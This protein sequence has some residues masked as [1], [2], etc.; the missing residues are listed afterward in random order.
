[1]P[2]KIATLTPAQTARMPE[3]V[4]KWLAIGLSTEPGDMDAAEE[5]VRN[6]YASIKAPAPKVVLRMASP[7]GAIVGGLMAEALLQGSASAVRSQVESQV[8]DQVYSQVE[9]QVWNQVRRQVWNQVRNQVW[10]QVRSQVWS[11][12]E[13]QVESQVESQVWSQVRS[14]VGSQ[15]W[16]QVRRQVESRVGNQV[17]SRWSDS[18][19]QNLNAGWHA[20]VTFFRDV[21]GWENET[22]AAYANDEILSQH[23]SWTWWAPEVAAIVDKPDLLSR[24]AEGRLHSVTG[25]A[26]RYRDG[27]AI[28]AVHGVPVPADIIED[29]ASI[30]VARI[31]AEANAEVRRVMIDLYDPKRYLADSGAT[32]IQELPADHP[33]VGL[34]TARLLRKEVE[35]DEP[36][37]MVD[38]LNS[39]AEPDGSVKR[40][41]LRV[42][43]QAYGGEA[44]AYVHAAAASTWRLPDGALAFKRWQD[45]A[46]VF[47]S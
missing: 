4:E 36:I 11:Q 2:T 6:L 13:K 25:P 38:L 22:L 8:G 12:V 26:L 29:R 1:M 43:P 45:Y 41:Q 39:T 44:S 47:E 18:R 27:W 21:C 30:T 3:W 19:Y 34:R 5:A 9:N 7:F 17:E 14:Q 24:D 15:V 20:Y 42:D 33:I 10:N 32:V 35:D 31:D 40:Y 23:A 16:S 37:V 28:H 46:P